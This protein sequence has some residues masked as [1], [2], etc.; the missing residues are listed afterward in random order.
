MSVQA[1]T[2]T[3]TRAKSDTDDSMG[4]FW[5]VSRKGSKDR[6]PRLAPC[7]QGPSVT[8]R[9]WS[10]KDTTVRNECQ[11][12]PLRQLRHRSAGLREFS[13][14]GVR[15]K[16]G[17]YGVRE[18]QKSSN[19]PEKMQQRRARMALAPG[20]DQRIPDCLRRSPIT[21]RQPASTTPEPTKNFFSRYS[22]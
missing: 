22:A 10:S 9:D 16:S 15:D 14:E 8:L 13:G 1:A 5:P 21:V 20:T 19:R 11:L 6:H 18:A 17:G 4:H 12:A 7:S 3:S 2:E